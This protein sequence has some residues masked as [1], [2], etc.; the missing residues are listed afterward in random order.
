MPSHSLLSW[1]LLILVLGLHLEETFVLLD[2]Y[3]WE[4]NRELWFY[5][6]RKKFTCDIFACVLLTQNHAFIIGDANKKLCHSTSTT[7]FLAFCCYYQPLVMLSPSHTASWSRFSVWME[8]VGKTDTIK[9]K[10]N[11]IRPK[12]RR[13]T[14]IL[15][16]W[17]ACNDNHACLDTFEWS[18]FKLVEDRL[19]LVLC[20]QWQMLVL[21]LNCEGFGLLFVHLERLV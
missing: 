18:Y 6:F 16:F 2:F 12:C 15:S 11:L 5:K 7:F 1:L 14:L 8:L 17:I 9:M 21:F 4:C 3:F 19:L 10:I 13:P 20:G